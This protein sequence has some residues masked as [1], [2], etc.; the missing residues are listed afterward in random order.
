MVREKEAEEEVVV[1]GEHHHG[2][3][4]GGGGEGKTIHGE[5]ERRGEWKSH[6]WG[7]REK[8]R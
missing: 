8:R 3:L 2:E 5:G 4:G 1:W 6:P 7:G